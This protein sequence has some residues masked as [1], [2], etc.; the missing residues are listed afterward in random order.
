MVL[1]FPLRERTRIRAGVGGRTEAEVAYGSRPRFDAVLRDASGEPV[2]GADVEVV[3]RFAAGS[4]LEPAGRT[5]TTDG[6]GRLRTRLTRGPSRTVVVRWAGSRRYLGAES[7]PV[8]VDVRGQARID[9]IQ[10]N[11]RAGRRV[12][13]RGSIGALGAALPHGKLVELQVRG[14]GVRRYRTVGHAFRTD[15]RG[16]WR[17]RYRFD[18]FYTEPARF[19]FRLRVPRERRWPY[20]APALSRPR[21]LTVRPRR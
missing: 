12:V 4:S 10:R 9:R 21:S 8:A 6:R 19:R 15:H 13:F 2:D 17:M 11:V 1:D 18:R 3:E 7:D 14:S 20:L 16:H 5:L